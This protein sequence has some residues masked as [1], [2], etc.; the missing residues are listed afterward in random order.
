MHIG[1]TGALRRSVQRFV[2]HD[3]G[4]LADHGKRE[5]VMVALRLAQD[6]GSRGL[7]RPTR[8]RLF[9]AIGIRPLLLLSKE[10]P[11]VPSAKE[12]RDARR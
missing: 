9:A 4:C 11:H 1:Q 3:Q 12:H 10:S 2:T 6:A 8:V 5:T 7:T